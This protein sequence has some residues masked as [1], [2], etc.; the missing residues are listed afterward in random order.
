M[1]M[2]GPRMILGETGLGVVELADDP[3]RQ[4]KERMAVMKKIMALWGAPARV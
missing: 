2:R 3:E 1:A 4:T